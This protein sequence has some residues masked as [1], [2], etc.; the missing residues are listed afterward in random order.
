VTPVPVIVPVFA[1]PELSPTVV[2]LP[3]FMPYAATRPDA[4]GGGDVTV[5]LK[6]VVRINAPFVPVTVVVVVPSGVV[7][8]VVN[9]T[10]VVQVGVH[11]VG[12]KL[13]V[14]P[15]G[16][17]LALKLTDAAVPDTSVAVT[18]FVVPLP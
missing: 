5:R 18:L 3:S 1:F 11:D 9:V 15:A 4:G 2:P 7:P 17:P 14:V 13:A 8:D 12:E 16:K 6:L 10:V